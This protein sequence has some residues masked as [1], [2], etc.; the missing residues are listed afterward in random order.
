MSDQTLT[1]H[2]IPSRAGILGFCLGALALIIVLVAFF[3]G[4]FA[5]QQATGVTLGDIAAEA[6]KATLRN[7]LGMDQPAPQAASWTIDRVLWVAVGVLGAAAIL[8]GAIAMIRRERRD[9]AA[10]AVGLGVGAVTLQFAATAL[11]L[12]VGALILCALIYAL[13]DFFSFLG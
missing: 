1:S 9:V 4:P 12:I 11:M 8:C 13:G 5:P 7:W 2:P 3:G 10:W 6:G